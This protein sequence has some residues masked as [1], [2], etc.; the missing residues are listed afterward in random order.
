MSRLL[1]SIRAALV[2]ACAL[3]TAQCCASHASA[4]LRDFSDVLH[5]QTRAAFNKDCN[6]NGGALRPRDGFDHCVF[7]GGLTVT[8]FFPEARSAKAQLVGHSYPALGGALDTYNAAVRAFGP[9]R[10]TTQR[11]SCTEWFWFGLTASKA[12]G[13]Q[14]HQDALSI[15]LC[16]DRYQVFVGRQ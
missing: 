13:S 15:T 12:W 2:V 7:P 14:A 10:Q 3:Y 9:P 11:K 4:D 5:T 8:A 6:A 16:A 1:K